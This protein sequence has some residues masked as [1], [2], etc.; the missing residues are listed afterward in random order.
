MKNQNLV[1][2]DSQ[3]LYDIL[4]ELNEFLN[5]NL[6]NVSKKNFSNFDFDKYDDYIIL[7]NNDRLKNTNKLI[8][9]DFPIKISNLIEKIN[10][11]FLK[12]KFNKQSHIQVGNYFIDINSRILMKN[13]D[14]LD[15]TE[16]EINTIIYLKKKDKPITIKE[17]QESVWS[18]QSK[19]ETHT[20]ETHIHRLRKKIK[21]KFNDEN[22]IISTKHGYQINQKK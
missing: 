22:F 9:N 10:I 8:F 20:V 11:E 1:I 3:A 4:N 14:K 12:K 18:Y 16:K 19:L 7:V 15:V 21:E 17:L 5:F 13:N 2:Y 6:I